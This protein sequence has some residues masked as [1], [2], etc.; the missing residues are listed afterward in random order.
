MS[1]KTKIPAR[2][3]DFGNK[4]LNSNIFGI[5]L[6]A[7]GGGSGTWMYIDENENIVD[8]PDRFFESHPT[9]KPMIKP[10]GNGYTFESGQISMVKIPRFYIRTSSNG[11]KFW[12]AP[13][14]INPSYT[15]EENDKAINE[16]YEKGF[17][18]H[19]AF[20]KS[21][22]ESYE[23]F[24]IGSYPL[25]ITSDGKALSTGGDTALV[26]VQPSLFSGYCEARSDGYHM[27]TIYELSAIQML[28]ILQCKTTNLQ[29][30]CGRGRVNADGVGMN[31]DTTVSTTNPNLIGPA[32]ANYNG[33]YALWGNA[34]QVVNGIK[35]DA[36]NKLML[37]TRE[38]EKIYRTTDITL[39]YRENTTTSYAGGVDYGFYNKTLM[40]VGAQ[41]DLSEV[42]LP[43]FS[44]LSGR[45]E[46]G[47]YSDAVYCPTGI[48]RGEL[49]CGVGGSYNS[50]DEA[51]LFA[52][53][54]N[55]SPNDKYDSVT[56]RLAKY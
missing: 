13:D 46:L 8:L 38:G 23:C 32:T 44:F 15:P 24:Y 40:D 36:N 45:M 29:K 7:N 20:I 39:P 51:G 52:Y 28:A 48:H 53:N 3:I 55:I 14:P 37:W 50:D 18:L 11:D 43:D 27:W 10:D 34:W 41:Y 33:I 4:V 16:L 31:G 49:M 9:F 26:K 21:E 56:S 5:K 19:P 1:W 54:F 6:V 12:I 47:S 42:F 30:E 2:F 17:R 25:S 35:I 22:S